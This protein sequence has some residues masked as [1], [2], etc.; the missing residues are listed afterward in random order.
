M[1][2]FKSFLTLTTYFFTSLLFWPTFIWLPYT[3]FFV[4]LFVYYGYNT[5]FSTFEGNT[6][7]EAVIELSKL[8][9]VYFF[10]LLPVTVSYYAL[11]SEPAAAFLFVSYFKGF[12]A[13]HVVTLYLHFFYVY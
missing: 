13:Y 10:L 7:R 5:S 9:F 3:F 2:S 8:A 1:Q 6:R 12:L 11:L 4:L